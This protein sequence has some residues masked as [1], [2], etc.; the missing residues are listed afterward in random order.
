MQKIV[1]YYD[2]RS[3]AFVIQIIIINKKEREMRVAEPITW[4]IRHPRLVCSSQRGGRP[5]IISGKSG[6]VA[7]NVSL[8]MTSR[9]RLLRYLRRLLLIISG[10]KC[11]GR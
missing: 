11:C 3:E 5:R 4:L 7:N 8:A 6:V 2:F 1:K 10:Y 9:L